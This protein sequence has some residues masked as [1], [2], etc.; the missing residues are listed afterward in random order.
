M[1]LIRGTSLLGFTE[2]VEELGGAPDLARDLLRE[3]HLPVGSVGDHDSF[4]S[5]RGVVAVLELAAAATGADDFGR[6]L[7]LRQGLDILG[8]LGVAA[9]TAATV[10]AALGAIEQYMAVYS[11]AIAVSVTAAPDERLA[12]FE[13]RIIADRPPPHRQSAELALGVSLRVF[14]LLAG[15]DFRPV[16]VHLR[17]DEPAGGS[18]HGDYFGCPVRFGSSGYGFSFH[19]S[20][21]ERPLSSDS[22]V[23]AVVSEYLGSIAPSSSSATEPVVRLIRR[24]LATGGPDLALVA[25]QLALHPRT[26]QRQLAAGGTSFATLVD[27][28]RRTEA[29]RYLRETT[30][31]L[32]QLSG[33]LG[34]S[35]QS[36]LSRACRRWFGCAPSVVRRGQATSHAGT[37]AG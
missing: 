4:V 1:S 33:V 3:A 12:R 26:L 18:D 14:R 8:P 16:A 35:E 21:L 20:T 7:A 28:V 23:H 29:E 31:P 11:P 32:S 36:A 5:Y 22:S 10:G 17:H 25:E 19:R 2:L 37:T 24:M 9:R 15:D 13:W 6:R 27:E 30:M 34:F